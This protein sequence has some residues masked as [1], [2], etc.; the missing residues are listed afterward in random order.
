[1]KKNILYLLLF[2][3]VLSA[4]N[5]FLDIKPYG[6]TIPQTAEEFSALVHNM[7]RGV[8]EGVT[9]ERYIVGTVAE[10]AMY[11]EIADNME[12]NL[13]EYPGGQL[14]TTYLGDVVGGSASNPY[15]LL[16]QNIRNCNIVL[17]EFSDGR[18][19][20]EGRNLV[21][22]AYALRGICYYQ[23]LRRFCPPAGSDDDRLGVP[24]VTTFDMEERP[25]RSTFAETAAQIEDDLN[26]AL[27]YHVTDE[28]FRVNDDV[29]TGFLARYYFWTGQYSA[30]RT[31]AQRLMAK[32]PLL[33]GEDYR[34]MMQEQYG[35]NGNMLIKGNLMRTA[36]SSV[37]GISNSLVYRPL[38]VRFVSLF[39]EGDRDIRYRLFIGAKRK[40][41]KTIFAC[42]R[43]AEMYLIA[44]ESSYHLGETEEAL[45]QLNDFRRS[46]IENVEDYT[47]QTLPAIREDEY[48]RTD[49][50]G[51]PLT[52]LL[53]AILCERRK[54]L[55]M[56]GDRLFELKRNGRPE[57]WVTRNGL[58][59]Y[60][61]RFMYTFPL[62]VKDVLLQPGLKQN[63]GYEETY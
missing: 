27:R 17:D 33:D 20:S 61:R 46:R 59:Y 56:E 38:S 39:V 25:V 30:A 41:A 43:A 35:L 52:R 10:S 23:L 40:N 50:T 54:E 12:T 29:V 6:K 13:T 53:Y 42:M 15:S 16:Y 11:E 63:P 62:P 26:Q 34:Y 14:L 45:R 8:D 18:D 44:M 7:L 58:K 36:T 21:G 1:M 5:D 9:E 2:P 51:K 31:M 47:E 4:C 55:Y 3:L 49:A 37:S 28:M 32:Y 60:T 57:F 24:L 22:T 48:I 19:T